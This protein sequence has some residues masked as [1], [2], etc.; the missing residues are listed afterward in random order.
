M[1]KRGCSRGN[2]NELRERNANEGALKEKEGKGNAKIC[3]TCR[4]DMQR[5]QKSS[6]PGS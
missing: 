2:Y 3:R 5:K 1:V 6:N 4:E